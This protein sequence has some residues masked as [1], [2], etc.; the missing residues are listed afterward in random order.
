V[1]REHEAEAEHHEKQPPYV[2]IHAEAAFIQD[3]ETVD[4]ASG[5]RHGSP[6][7]KSIATA[8]PP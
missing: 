2:C 8:P 6:D 1:H 4:V 3:C 7:F 5:W